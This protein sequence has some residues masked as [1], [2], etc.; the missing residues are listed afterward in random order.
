MITIYLSEYS[1]MVNVESTV[2]H[3]AVTFEP[4]KAFA[5]SLADNVALFSRFGSKR[6][7]HNGSLVN[8]AFLSWSDKMANMSNASELKEV[9]N[10]LD[11]T[12]VNDVIK[13]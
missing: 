4:N 12:R 2:L 3:A 11:K 10:D 5:F 8:K 13:R 7:C 9:C 1:T 6:L